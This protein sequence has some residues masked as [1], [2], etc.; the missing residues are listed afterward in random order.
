MQ[1]SYRHTPFAGFLLMLGVSLLAAAPASAQ[2]P[3]YNPWNGNTASAQPQGF[4]Q[5]NPIT[6]TWGFMDDGTLINEST[7]G[8]SNLQAR[9]NQIYAGGQS[10][11][12]PLF[13]SVFDRWSSISGLTYIYE[14]N[15][16]GITMTGSASA[17]PGVLGVRA[18]LRIGGKNIDGNSG[19]L[20][21]NYFPTHGNMVIDTND[22][23]YNTTTN[24]SLRLRNVVSHEHGHGMGMPHNDSNNAQ[25]LMEPFLNTG[26]DGPQYHDILAAQRMYGDANEKS[27]GGAGNDS[28]GRATS[29]GSVAYNTPRQIG[30]SAK[31]LVVAPT[32]TDFVSIDDTNDTDWYSFAAN[33]IGHLNV[34]LEALGFLYNI[35]PQN[36][37]GN[38]PFDTRLRSN[39]GLALF[40]TNGS[41][42]LASANLNG[43]GGN[44]SIFFT[45]STAGTYFL[46]ITGVDN[47]DSIALDTQFYGLTLNFAPV[48]EPATFALIGLAGMG[49]M[50]VRRRQ[51]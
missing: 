36:A 42:L 12:Q 37:G 39:L 3:N 47:A 30:Q 51:S 48:P 33:A 24:N 45:L 19:V 14:P 11:W 43:L 31:T 46:R 20:A 29:L 22:T 40:D 21:Y 16:D 9:L 32:A 1:F 5:G 15:D 34:H 2:P 35:T 17:D 7:P 13:Q 49:W 26:F 44:E 4:G 25:F 8:T 23:F 10:T 41:T 50:V 18:D 6:L 27:N 28:F 38:V